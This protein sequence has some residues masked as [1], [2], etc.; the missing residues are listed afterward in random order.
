MS[1]CGSLVFNGQMFSSSSPT[2]V[3]V[4]LGGVDDWE[5]SGSGN[6]ASVGLAGGVMDALTGESGG[7]DSGVTGVDGG[8]GEACTGGD[9]EAGVVPAL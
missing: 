7:G 1:H 4:G 3:V 9:G 6:W 8:D 2:S 5:A